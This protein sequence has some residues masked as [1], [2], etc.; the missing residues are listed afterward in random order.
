LLLKLLW[1]K[2]KLIDDPVG[3]NV[4]IPHDSLQSSSL[5]VL[6][7]NVEIIKKRLPPDDQV[8][9]VNNHNLIAETHINITD[10]M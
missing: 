6:I 4:L 7:W 5:Q 8:V 3:L 9:K 10:L 2:P 1:D